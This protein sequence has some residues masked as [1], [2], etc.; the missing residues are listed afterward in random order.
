MKQL[1]CTFHFRTISFFNGATRKIFL[2]TADNVKLWIQIMLEQFWTLYSI[3]MWSVF[4]R[5]FN[6]EWGLFFRSVGLQDTRNRQ[7][8]N[9]SAGYSFNR[10]KKGELFNIYMKNEDLYF[11]LKTF[12]LMI[13]CRVCEWRMNYY[14][15]DE[16][17]YKY[18]LF[19]SIREILY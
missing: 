17:L 15:A 8:V 18:L 1:E 13:E 11:G 4:E 10:G 9:T 14:I 6:F 12:D 16:K 7:I 3:Q 19:I 2:V 5:R